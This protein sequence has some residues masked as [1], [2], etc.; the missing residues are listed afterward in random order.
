[1]HVFRGRLVQFK[2]RGF[3]KFQVKN[4]I[5]FPHI[6]APTELQINDAIFEE[7]SELN[8]P[9][10]FSHN[11]AF[12]DSRL[13]SYGD[14]SSFLTNKLN[15]LIHVSAS[16]NVMLDPAQHIFVIRGFRIEIVESFQ[17]ISMFKVMFTFLG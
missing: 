11:S 1:M 8:I 4:F 9:D 5:D 2:L 13:T 7:I 17:L 16:R 10:K 3:E 14:K 6:F 15:N 12:S